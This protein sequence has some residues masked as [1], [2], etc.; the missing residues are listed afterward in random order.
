VNTWRD[1]WFEEPGVRVLYVLPRVWTDRV[2]PL[3]LDPKPRE[4]VR[5]MVGRAEVITPNMEWELLKQVVRYSDASEAG[6]PQAVAAARELGLGRFLEPV[7]RRLMGKVP[8]RQF[9]TLA[10]E[11]MGKASQPAAGTGSSIAK[12]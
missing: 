10:W 5:V 11:L 1:S 9:N 12:K 2:L 3:T 7:T 4:T 8:D 6:R